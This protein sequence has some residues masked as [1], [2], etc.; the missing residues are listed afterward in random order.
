MT[1]ND[2][3]ILGE[4][5]H[6]NNVNTSITGRRS[7]WSTTVQQQVNHKDSTATMG[8]TTR[9]RD[10]LRLE[11]WYVFLSFLITTNEYIIDKLQHVDNR[12]TT[13]TVSHKAQHVN[14][15]TT[16]QQRRST[17]RARD[18]MRLEPLY[19]FFFFFY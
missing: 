12:A 13:T 14:T 7:Q 8:S 15:S 11:P 9:A 5:Q 17:T 4:L 18:A 6:V 19:V 16:G 1:T 2:Y 3:I 10:A